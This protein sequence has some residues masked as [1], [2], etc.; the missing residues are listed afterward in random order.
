MA[1][2]QT[3]LLNA[4]DP[5]HS[6]VVEACAGSGKTW[7]LVSRI[8]RLLLA[9]VAPSEIL[10]ITFTRKGAR[11]MQERLS[12]WLQE[13]ATHRDDAWVKSFLRERG[14]DN[15]DD[16]LPQ[17]RGLLEKVLTAQPG[18]KINTFHGWFAD[19]VQRA[20]LQAGI[21]KG[22]A[23]TEA[24]YALAQEAWQRYA[25]SLSGPENSL[26]QRALDDLF[27]ELGIHNTRK[28]LEK[29]LVKRA[30]W[31]SYTAG[32]E[33]PVK[34]AIDQL[35]RQIGIDL[36]T[37]YA[38]LL[39]RDAVFDDALTHLVGA[40]ESGKDT[41][42]KIVAALDLAGQIER[43][44]DRLAAI[45]PLIF[46]KAN[47]L[48]VAL[49]KF[50]EKCGEPVTQALAVVS[51][52]MLTAR[53]ALIEQRMVRINTSAFVAGHGLLEHY[54][55]LKVERGLLD[56][57]DVEYAAYTLLRH[58]DHAEYMQYKL[59]VR[60]RHILVDEFQDTNPLQ[61]MTLQAWLQASSDAGLRPT[62]FL[63]GDPKQSIFHFRR[64]DA[65]LFGHASE[66]LQQEY[67]AQ[68][69][70]QNVS[71]RSGSGVLG[72]VNAVFS[73]AK[74]LRGF[75]PHQ[76]HDVELTGAFHL[77]PLPTAVDSDARPSAPTGLRDLLATPQASETDVR[78]VLEANDLAR[79]IQAIVANWQVHDGDEL[80]TAEYR[81]VMI[82]TR[83]RTQLR[84][85]ELALSTAGIPYASARQGGL[86]DS[87]EAKDLIALLQF[88][89][90]PGDNLSLVHALRAPLFS[91][92]DDDLIALAKAPG[93]HWW[94]RLE[95]NAHSAS[96]ALKRAHACL[97][98]WL[99]QAPHLPVH[100]LLDRIFFKANLEQ[101][102]LQAV[103][104]SMMRS[105]HANLLAFMELSLSLDSGRYPSLGRF[106]ADL[107]ALQ[108]SPDMEAPDEGTLAEAGNA[109]RILTVH[110]AK[111]L[112]APIVWIIGAT[113]KSKSGDA[114]DVLVTWPTGAE[115]PEH[116]SF[117]TTNDQHGA[118]R[119]RF[120]SE[121]ASILEQEDANLLYVAMTRAKQFL[122]VSGNQV[123]KGNGS[124]YDALAS[125]LPPSKLPIELSSGQPIAAFRDKDINGKSIQFPVWSQSN[126]PCGERK[127]SRPDASRD[128]GIKLHALLEG[129]RDG[130]IEDK[131]AARVIGNEDPAIGTA[132]LKHARSILA[133][134]HL[135]KFFDGKL[136]RTA[137]NEVSVIDA[138]GES[139]RLD[140]VVEF[141]DAVWILDYKSASSE[142][143]RASEFMAEYRAQLLRYRRALANVYPDQPLHCGLIFGDGVLQEIA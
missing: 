125:V 107:K 95:A 34:F 23:L 84:D 40:L 115:R 37:D 47:T 138:D 11:E 139:L 140:R 141:V 51:E 36:N 124:W 126:A 133:A 97:A 143:A 108:R 86:L 123:G 96:P 114:Y 79:G 70:R 129:A 56:F 99:E 90:R 83:S 117:L 104:K 55:Q 10:A 6:V 32:E 2:D 53:N 30:E 4:L 74:T 85:Y 106:I 54:Q 7:L 62:V 98:D 38:A 118:A 88:L 87:L 64:A 130:I 27:R 127:I 14:I 26:Q 68:V 65:R 103:P 25:M 71:R 52:K 67:G 109:V 48:L 110:G 116:F 29:F 72:A 122:I 77:L 22:F 76:A 49:K 44:Q 50:C 31:W 132:L 63:V 45:M 41:Q 43:P 93:I 20:P 113:T 39:F 33:D 102:Y 101:R 17:A 9:G 89:L 128:Y 120:F 121:E 46:T 100:D 136:H 119:E 73:N 135:R 24:A 12:A 131:T 142:T 28:L 59:D 137:R 69:L 112:E 66:F 111:S 3:A 1:A 19:L 82:L 80:R 21:A 91:C 92:S 13:L 57:T 75:V 42:Q 94:Q 58:S 61:W 134:G 35:V 81:D 16:L 15:A 5:K 18:I 60:Y 105:V 8:V 78:R